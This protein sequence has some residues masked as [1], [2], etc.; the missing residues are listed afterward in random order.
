MVCCL[1]LAAYKSTDKRSDVPPLQTFD[2][3]FQL[4]N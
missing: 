4:I 1:A 3:N 2:F